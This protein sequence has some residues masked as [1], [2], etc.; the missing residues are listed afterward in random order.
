VID[1]AIVGLGRWGCRLVEATQGKSQK[2]RFAVGVDPDMAAAREFAAKHHFTLLPALETVLSERSV[3]AV[4]LATPHSLHVPQVLAASAA[5]KH[6]FCEK[7]LALTRTDAERMVES[8]ERARV[9]LGVGHNRRWWPAMRELERIVTSGE[10]GTLLH[11][12]SHNSNENS[13]A[14]GDGWR[15][16]PHESPGGGMTGAGLH[17]LDAMIGLAGPVKRV[18]AQFLERKPPPAPQDTVAALLEFDS[19][20]SGLL[21]TVRATPFYWRVHAFGTTGNVEVLG[22]TELVLRMS[23]ALPER[24]QFPA[25]D[26]LCG[27]MEAFTDAVAGRAAFPISSAQMLDPV[28]ALEQVVDAIRGKKVDSRHSD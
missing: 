14:V 22:E 2:L 15:T 16:L 26:A 21:A 4:V 6:V 27:E 1:A 23:G 28:S 11:I 12:E 9:V 20:V 7:P 18:R 24:R 13:N 19:G 3:R 8:C 25:S 10:L 17:A 5:G